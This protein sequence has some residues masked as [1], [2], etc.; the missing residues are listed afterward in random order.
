L[1]LTGADTASGSEA[2]EEVADAE[3]SAVVEAP[4]AMIEK[5]K[6]EVIP[7]EPKKSGDVVTFVRSV[8]EKMESAIEVR[9]KPVSANQKVGRNDPCPCGAKKPDGRPVKFK[10]CHGR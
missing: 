9:E 8:G 3:V 1:V 4:R 7:E 5:P 2:I 6:A 10:H